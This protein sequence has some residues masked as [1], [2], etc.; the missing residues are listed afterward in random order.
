VEASDGTGTAASLQAIVDFLAGV[1]ATD[2]VDSSVSWTHDQ[3]GTDPWPLGSTS[4][5]FTATDDAGNTATCSAV[6]GVSG[7]L[8]EGWQY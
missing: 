5:T 3:T 7:G 4:T 1:S 8:F 6:V 2:A